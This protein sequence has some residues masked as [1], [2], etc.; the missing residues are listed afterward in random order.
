MFKTK[1]MKKLSKIKLQEI[2][3]TQETTSEW[4][5]GSV[6][7]VFYPQ[8]KLMTVYVSARITC[9]DDYARPALGV[10]TETDLIHLCKLI[11]GA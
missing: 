2:G 10:I 1:K 7:V 8:D 3:F 4:W 9:G 6:F 11:N 5:N